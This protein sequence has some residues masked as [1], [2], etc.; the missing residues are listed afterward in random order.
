MISKTPFVAEQIRKL[1]EIQDRVDY[2]WGKYSEEDCVILAAGPSLKKYPVDYIK[3]KLKD[4]LVI[5]IKQ[6]IKDFYDI[7]DFHV[8]NFTNYE[9]Y[10][11]YQLDQNIV[12]WEVFEQYH[13]Q[14][15]LENKIPCDIM[16]PIEGNHGTDTVDKM[17]G[18]QAKL[19][20]FSDWELRK[21]L[22][23]WYGP[24]IMYETVMHLCVHLGVK[25]ITTLGW[26]IG[27]LSK[28]GD[29][30]Y[31]D[32]WQ[33]HSYQGQDNIVYAPTPMNKYE[34]EVVRDSTPALYKYLQSQGINLQIIS[35]TNPASDIIPRVEL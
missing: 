17:N 33:D 7:T 20:N 21:T 11:N 16:L 23:R 26:D 18:T 19:E 24:G 12:V 35:D 4:K 29:D 32:V 28:F 5:S 22:V 27:D 15:I 3:E 10:E 13:P 6:S 2:L 34:I 30:P 9:P 31:E 1:P 14:M 25:S 8:L